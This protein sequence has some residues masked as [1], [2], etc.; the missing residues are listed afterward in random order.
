MSIKVL[1]IYT[2]DILIIKKP[3]R[4]YPSKTY[5]DTPMSSSLKKTFKL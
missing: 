1:L 4:K 3:Q 5:W 2:S